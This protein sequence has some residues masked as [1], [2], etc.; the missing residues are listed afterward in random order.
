MSTIVQQ[1]Y[2]VIERLDE[3]SQI[4]VLKFA[5]FLALESDSDIAIY[6]RVKAEDDGYRISSGDLRKKYGI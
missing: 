4:S 2:Q 1:A 5:E 3:S 6:D